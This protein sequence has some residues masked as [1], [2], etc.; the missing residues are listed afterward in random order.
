MNKNKTD[1]PPRSSRA[2]P[3]SSLHK[4]TFCHFRVLAER[5]RSLLR[6]SR[7]QFFLRFSNYFSGNDGRH[8][9][10]NRRGSSCGRQ[11]GHFRTI[12]QII[13]IIRI[14]KR[15]PK[16]KK[17]KKK[18]V[19]VDISKLTCKHRTNPPPWFQL[20][21][22]LLACPC[23]VF[24]SNRLPPLPRRQNDGRHTST[25]RKRVRTAD[26]PNASDPTSSRH[27]PP[28]PYFRQNEGR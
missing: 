10:R 11:R 13:R 16:V 28:P 6:L 17:K 21:R 24:C 9:D 15:L 22:P 20:S 23:R 19:R 5:S 2:S 7:R 1:P 26:V 12:G 27:M 3:L 4:G 25:E 8:C 14:G 18:P